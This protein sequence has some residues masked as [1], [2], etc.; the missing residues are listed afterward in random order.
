MPVQLGVVMD[1]ITHINPNKD[2]TLLLLLAAIKKDWNIVYFEQ[3]HLFY[4]NNIA[5]EGNYRKD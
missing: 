3:K 5:K 2:T 1:P 4:D